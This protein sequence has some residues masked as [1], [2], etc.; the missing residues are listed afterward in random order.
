MD[1]ARAL[2]PVFLSP[3]FSFLFVVLGVNKILRRVLPL[4]HF[5]GYSRFVVRALCVCM[6]AS[7]NWNWNRAQRASKQN[8]QRNK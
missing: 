5:L 1:I 7:G 2:P 3:S 4:Q 6:C 8:E